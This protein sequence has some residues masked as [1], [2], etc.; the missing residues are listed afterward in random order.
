MRKVAKPSRITNVCLH[1]HAYEGG[2]KSQTQGE[3]C[4]D[5]CLCENESAADISGSPPVARRLHSLLRVPR[6]SSKP[7]SRRQS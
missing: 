3:D 6:L 4:F 5:D 7:Y 1:V 2:G